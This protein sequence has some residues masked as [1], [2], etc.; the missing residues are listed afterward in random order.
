MA[1]AETRLYTPEDLLTMPDGKRFELVD[2]QLLERTMSMWSSYVAGE[3]FARIRDHVRA[4]QL[5]LSLPEGTTFQCFPDAPNQVRKADAS[6]IRGDRITLEEAAT[7]GHVHIAPDLAVE[8]VSP[9]DVYYEVHEKVQDYLDAGVLLVWV[10]DPSTR[11][12]EVHRQDGAGTIL[13][14]KDSLDGESVL[15][16]F[17]CLVADLFQPPAGIKP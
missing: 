11:S 8:V 5:G 10:V 4:N 17:R 14:E 3:V 15:R 6:F 7:E 2:G 13:R 12:V 9:N 16:G 1:T